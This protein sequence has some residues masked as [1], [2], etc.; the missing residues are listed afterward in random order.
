[1]KELT[2]ANGLSRRK[3]QLFVPR[4]SLDMLVCVFIAL[5]RD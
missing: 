1:L 2:R 3:E 5:S 4:L